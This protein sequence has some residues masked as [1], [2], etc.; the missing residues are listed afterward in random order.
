MREYWLNI[1][2]SPSVMLKKI[3]LISIKNNRTSI[4]L[5]GQHL[6]SIASLKKDN[7][8]MVLISSDAGYFVSKK[9]HQR[10]LCLPEVVF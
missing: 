10:K 4:A 6:Y 1:K 8:R 2:Q 5:R 7:W 3:N 9:T